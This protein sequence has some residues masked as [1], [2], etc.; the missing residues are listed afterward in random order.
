V[1]HASHAAATAGFPRLFDL[2]DTSLTSEHST[3]VRTFGEVA[4]RRL[5]VHPEA[6][7]VFVEQYRRLGT[8]LHYAQVQSG[9]RSVMVASAVAAEG[10]TLSA[11]NLAL[12]LSR[13]FNKRVLLVDGD[14]RKP[15]VHH[16]LQLENE[17]GLS[18]MLKRPSGRLTAQTLSPTLSVITGG[19]PDL[20]PVSLLVSD[21][22]GQFLAET[23]DQFDYVVV[24]TPPVVLFPDAEL[25]AGRLDTCVMVVNAITT[26][27]PMAARAVA[28]IGASRILG[29]VL[30]R[31]EPTE[32]A[33]GYSYGEYGYPGN[34]G[35]GR[36]FAWWRSS[37]R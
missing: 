19:H 37:R 7:P 23:R 34:D 28:A 20:D 35:P 27:S 12:M 15:S 2:R 17:Y 8:A 3:G 4:D 22:A 29:V 18:E 25:F 31:A 14:L 11:T 33:G 30:N 9:V 13:S 21:A 16:L 36:R 1:K 10:K 24:D 32:I 5:V 6:D 26:A